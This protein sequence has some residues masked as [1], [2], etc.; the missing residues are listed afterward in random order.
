MR[1]FDIL[2]SS[3]SLLLFAPVALVIAII[4]KFSGEGDVL[5]KQVRWGKDL[6]PFGIFKYATMLRN[7]PKIG[8]GLISVRN[9]PRVFPFG[10]FLRMTKLNEVPQLLNILRGDMGIVGPRPMVPTDIDFLPIEVQQKVYSVRPGLT[11]IGSIAFRDEEKILS[12]TKKSL[13]QCY[14]EDIAPLK[15]DLELWYVDHKSM[16]LDFKLIF[17]TAWVI[18]FPDSTLY[19]KLFGSDWAKYESRFKALYQ[20]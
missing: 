12:V 16:W 5:Y 18:L 10:R 6:K 17:L 15:A 20:K 13:R 19:Q 11:G 7:S 9:D 8:T 14:C 4:Q 3:I 1:F 2:L